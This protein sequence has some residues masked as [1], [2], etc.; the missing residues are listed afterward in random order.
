MGLDVIA[1]PN[2]GNLLNFSR[3]FS[4][5]NGSYHETGFIPKRF[6]DETPPSKRKGGIP[7]GRTGLNGPN[8]P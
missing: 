8:G 5:M 4:A 6:L 3:N 2:S 1:S 7:R